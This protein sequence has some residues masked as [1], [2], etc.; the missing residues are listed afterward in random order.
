[1]PKKYVLAF[2]LLISTASC[3]LPPG[4][5][6]EL[7]CPPGMCLKSRFP[8]PREGMNGARSMFYE[9]CDEGSGNTR[10]PRSWGERVDMSVKR[11]LVDNGWHLEQCTSNVDGRCGGGNWS[12]VVLMTRVDS[13]LGRMIGAMND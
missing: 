8:A 1:M 4:F 10:R 13:A 6:E 3:A 9:C 12:H 7:Y 11:D 2:W 5:E